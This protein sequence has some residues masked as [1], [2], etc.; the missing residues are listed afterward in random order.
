MS[1]KGRKL[2]D[3]MRY[4]EITEIKFQ[5]KYL[6]DL[7]RYIGNL[8]LNSNE[9][10]VLIGSLMGAYNNF[11]KVEDLDGT[12]EGF[13]K[14]GREVKEQL[15]KK[16]GLDSSGFS[17][18]EVERYTDFRRSLAFILRQVRLCKKG[19]FEESLERCVGDS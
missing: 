1:R 4:M 17:K 13:R 12:L 16:D 6:E 15:K 9:L 8:G 18:E 3:Y 5:R 10:I 11:V 14:F 7:G 19:V 2:P